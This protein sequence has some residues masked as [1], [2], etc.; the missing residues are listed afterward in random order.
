MTYIANSSAV[1][2]V[3]AVLAVLIAAAPSSSSPSPDLDAALLS[4]LIPPGS[5]LCDARSRGSNSSFSFSYVPSPPGTW[6]EPNDDGDDDEDD[7]DD[8]DD[9]G[10]DER[11]AVEDRERLAFFAEM[12]HADPD[13]NRTWTAR[14]G[15]GGN[16]YSL[17]GAYGEALPPPD[18]FR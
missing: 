7:K 17:S 16:V 1:R 6:R 4:D 18:R 3:V 10:A 2:S 11:A 5:P 8:K 14:F 15:S 9:G 12:R 13:P